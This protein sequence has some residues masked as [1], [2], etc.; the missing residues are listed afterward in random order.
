MF[1][2]CFLKQLFYELSFLSLLSLFLLI[3]FFFHVLIVFDS[4]ILQFF[5]FFSSLVLSL[6]QSQVNHLFFFLF[7]L[8]FLLL[9][10]I[11]LVKSLLKFRNPLKLCPIP[12]L[13]L[14]SF[15]LLHLILFLH[16][17][18]KFSFLLLSFYQCFSL[19]LNQSLNLI[20]YKSS[21]FFILHSSLFLSLIFVFYLIFQVNKIFFL[22]LYDLFSSLFK[23]FLLL[24]LSFQHLSFN[25]SLL[26]FL[27]KSSDLLFG[28]L[29]CSLLWY[30]RSF[31]FLFDLLYLRIRNEY[32]F[33]LN[34]FMNVLIFKF[35]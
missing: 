8:N 16:N 25:F 24:N 5:D 15:L 3:L 13:L 1:C 17:L 29:T 18:I 28:K 33:D 32:F 27:L 30:I 7:S 9:K 14:L 26:S 2:M 11:S 35:L 20:I 12:C 31:D 21:F 6:F 34:L 22:S 23:L 10:T 4:E 19:F